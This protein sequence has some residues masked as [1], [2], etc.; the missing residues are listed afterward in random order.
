VISD[1]ETPA[2]NTQEK[3]SKRVKTER[4]TKSNEQVE[5]KKKNLRNDLR[6]P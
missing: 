4:A 6:N 3:G 1:D 2:E 5:K